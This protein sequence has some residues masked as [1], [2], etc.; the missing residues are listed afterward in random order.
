MVFCRQ[1]VRR[2]SER[3]FARCIAGWPKSDGAKG[4]ASFSVNLYSD[5]MLLNWRFT[6]DAKTAGARSPKGPIFR[7]GLI[8]FWTHPPHWCLVATGHTGYRQLHQSL[9]EKIVFES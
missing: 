2:K 7:S 6:V 4:S 3:W 5:E 9:K 1:D 8:V